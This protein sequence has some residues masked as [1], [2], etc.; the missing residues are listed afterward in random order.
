V[1]KS[2]GMSN[3][4]DVRILDALEELGGRRAGVVQN[5]WYE[6]N[7][8][9]REVVA[10]CKQKGI[11]YQ[12]FWTLTGTPSLLHH[13]GVTALAKRKSSPR[14]ASPMKVTPAMIVYRMVQQWG[15]TPLA[16]STDEEHMKDGV[17]VEKI[18]L[19]D[20]DIPRAV[21]ILIM[22]S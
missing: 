7:G 11:S 15:I 10:Y 1:V 19:T 6:G 4:Y 20:D 5:R 2:I 17:A 8:F 3:V 12:S 9:D 14:A 22:G 18:P 16:G 21:R 13:P